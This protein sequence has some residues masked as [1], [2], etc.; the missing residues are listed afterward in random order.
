MYKHISNQRKTIFCDGEGTQNINIQNMFAGCLNCY[1]TIDTYYNN[2]ASC[3]TIQTGSSLKSA[4][5][6][7]QGRH[8]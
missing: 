1:R 3:L 4:V 5:K 2:T 8:A 7:L 6:P